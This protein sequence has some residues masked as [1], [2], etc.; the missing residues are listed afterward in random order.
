M[1][2]KVNPKIKKLLKTILLIFLFIYNVVFFSCTFIY[3]TAGQLL[4]YFMDDFTIFG[5]NFDPV[6]QVALFSSVEFWVWYVLIATIV[7][8]GIFISYIVL[9]IKSLKNY[10]I[11]KELCVKS[12]I[13]TFI[14]TALYSA[15]IIINDFI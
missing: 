2:N 1:L 14:Y 6:N 11:T 3:Y 12:I 10:G 15:P 4:A 13:F 7:F 5:G 8:L 9:S